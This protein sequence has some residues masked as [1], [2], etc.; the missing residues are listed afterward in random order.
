MGNVLTAF[1]REFTGEIK[2]QSK[3][4]SI[5]KYYTWENNSLQKSNG[6]NTILVDRWILHKSLP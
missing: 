2:T 1:L 6:V 4:L 5:Q 3:E